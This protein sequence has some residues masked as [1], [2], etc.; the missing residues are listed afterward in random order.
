MAVAMSYNL[1]S[2]IICIPTLKELFNNL[3][4]LFLGFLL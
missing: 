4:K 2:N 3:K 1:I